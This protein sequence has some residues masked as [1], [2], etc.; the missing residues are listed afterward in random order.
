M[1]QSHKHIERSTDCN[2][3]ICSLYMFDSPQ[4][5]VFMRCGHTIHRTCYKSHMESSYKCPI[6]Q[7]TVVNMESQFRALDRDIERQPMPEGFRD[8]K[9]LVGCNDCRAK[10]VSPY[11]WL[12]LKCQ[13]CDS[14]NTRQMA[15]IRDNVIDESAQTAEALVSATQPQPQAQ[16]DGAAPTAEIPIPGARDSAPRLRRHSSHFSQLLSP[17]AARGGA[18]FDPYIDSRLGRSASPQRG[19]YFRDQAVVQEPVDAADAGVWDDSQLDM[20]GRTRAELGL[21]EEESEEE[22]SLED[23]DKDE[24]MDDAEED[25]E[26]PIQLFG[27]R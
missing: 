21:E 4:T 19:D 17:S 6:C 15:I 26:D 1:S 3:P 8:T 24:M 7:Q 14:Y 22:S 25:E 13:I 9:A 20:F 12:G 16:L 2:C 10:S 23:E 5:V 11:H 18:G 27:H